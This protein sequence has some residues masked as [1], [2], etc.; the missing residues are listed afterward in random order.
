MRYK[1]LFLPLTSIPIVL[2]L[3][4]WKTSP[5]EPS[6]NNLIDPTPN[7]NQEDLTESESNSIFV[8]VKGAV[9]KPGVYELEEGERVLALIPMAGG[10]LPEANSGPINQAE[11]LVDEMVIYIPIVGEE[12]SVDEFSTHDNDGLI[13]INHADA[14][15]LTS[16]PGIGPSKAEAIINYRDENGSFKEVKDLLKVTGI[17]KKT[18]EQL[19]HLITVK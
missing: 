5:P 16:L 18:F 2:L 7:F 15:T 9:L 12:I 1:K 10:Y 11:R 17:G 4:F 13:N 6:L 3:F 8:E 19:E 14:S